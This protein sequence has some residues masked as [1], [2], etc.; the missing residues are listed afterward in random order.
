VNPEAINKKRVNSAI[1]KL[2]KSIYYSC[3]I[4]TRILYRYTCP[5]KSNI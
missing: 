1:A 4:T 5:N 2:K 3:R